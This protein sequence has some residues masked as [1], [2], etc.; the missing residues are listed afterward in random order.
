MNETQ[1]TGE[2][3]CMLIVD[4]R[5]HALWETMLS[6]LSPLSPLSP[7]SSDGVGNGDV[8]ARARA[9]ADE[10]EN[11]VKKGQLDLGDVQIRD[12]I[13]AT[14]TT[15]CTSTSTSTSTCASTS[16]STCACADHEHEEQKEEKEE[17]EVTFLVIERKTIADFCASIKDGRF[18]EQKYR[19]LGSS[20]TKDAHILYVVEGYAGFDRLTQQARAHGLHPTVL[21]TCIYDLMFSYGVHVVFTADVGDTA[22]VVLGL[23]DRHKS[24]SK[25]DKPSSCYRARS[26]CTGESTSTSSVAIEACV[27]AKKNK[28]ITP[29]SCYVMQLCQIPGVSM[30]TAKII[31][32]KWCSMQA[33]YADLSPKDDGVRIASFASLPTMGKKNARRVVDHLFP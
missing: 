13:S 10:G 23:W 32:G 21:Q 11:A 28:N 33:L 25:N 5:E 31:A 7:E 17:K 1:D 3:K 29:E 30:K 8:L 9:R 15:Q 24:R 20:E 4:S 18:K 27:A 6:L 16:T 22:Q 14:L 26:H 2:K 19:L 12:R